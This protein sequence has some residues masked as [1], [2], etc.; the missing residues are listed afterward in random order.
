MVLAHIGSG[1]CA[2]LSGDDKAQ[3]E[4][5]DNPAVRQCGSCDNCMRLCGETIGNLMSET[6]L[7]ID[8]AS[9]TAFS[10]ADL[11]IKSER[12]ERDLARVARRRRRD[13]ARARRQQL[14][15]AAAATRMT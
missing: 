5:R 4:S 2:D 14:A 8:A 13:S 10:K 12:V 1:C 7:P 15:L 6:S 9:V 11:G 3:N